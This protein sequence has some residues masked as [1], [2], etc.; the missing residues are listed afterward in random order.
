M[1]YV[2]NNPNLIPTNIIPT[3]ATTQGSEEVIED[4]E[5]EPEVE[6]ELT[7]EERHLQ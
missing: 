4:I 3:I 5:P 2:Q 1:Q 7:E 6:V